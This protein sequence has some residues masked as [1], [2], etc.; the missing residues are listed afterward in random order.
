[1]FKTKEKF[2]FFKAQWTKNSPLKNQSAIFFL[3]IARELQKIFF[4]TY[5]L[6]C[7]SLKNSGPSFCDSMDN[8]LAALLCVTRCT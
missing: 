3:K 7:S 6:V 4:E 1:M 8:V 5:G 2:V